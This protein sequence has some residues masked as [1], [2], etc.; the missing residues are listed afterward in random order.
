[1]TPIP[2]SSSSSSSSGG[3]STPLIQC[4]ASPLSL[5]FHVLLHS[6][7]ILFG[8]PV[9]LVTSKSGFTMSQKYSYQYRLYTKHFFVDSF[10]HHLI[11]TRSATETGD[12]IQTLTIPIHNQQTA[13]HNTEI[14]MPASQQSKKKGLSDLSS[15]TKLGSSY[16]PTDFDVICARGKAAKNHIGNRRFRHK[17]EESTPAY[18][19]ADSR[20]F[21]SM[22]VTRVVDWVRAASPTGGF[23]KEING[24]WYEVGDHLAREKVG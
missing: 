23:V 22:V 4:L 3:S 15:M 13:N 1:M 7:D 10:L 18:A 20:L 19:S 17:I 2:F 21:K 11:V 16:R 6:C 8:T 5:V 9:S 12:N 14:T 24:I